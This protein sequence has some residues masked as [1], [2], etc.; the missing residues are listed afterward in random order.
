MRRLIVS[1]LSTLDG[2]I[3]DPGG[4]SEFHHGGWAPPYFGDHGAEHALRKLQDCDLFLCGRVTYEFFSKY[5]PTGT[6]PYADHLNKMP[7][8]VASNT[9]TEPLTWNASLLKGDAVEEVGKLKQRPGKDIIV[10]G[11]GNLAA[12]LLRHCLVDEFEVWVFPLVLGTGK[13]LFDDGIAG[14]RLRL[15]D[16]KI[17]PTGVATL[18]YRPAK[19]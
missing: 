5:W 12:A 13:R 2:V 4:F 7:K 17:T 8:L 19:A 3:E 9:L 14:T 10:Y 11:A 16:Q 6:G 1:T 18:S 15:A